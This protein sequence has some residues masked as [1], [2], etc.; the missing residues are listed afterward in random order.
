M[1]YQDIVELYY[2]VLFKNRSEVSSVCY[3]LKIYN[4]F[5]KYFIIFV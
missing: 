4:Y 1:I 5:S 2:W 3:F